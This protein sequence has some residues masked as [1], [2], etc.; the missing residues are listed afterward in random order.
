MTSAPAG[1]ERTASQAER[2]R[3]L[4]ELFAG[5]QEMGRLAD[6]YNRTSPKEL[7][8][9]GAAL[10]TVRRRVLDLVD[11]YE[12]WLPV[13]AMSRCP[14]SGTVV[15]HS[16]DPVGLDGPWW[17]AERPIR[18]IEEL[19]PTCFALAGALTLGAAPPSTPR[20]CRP[21]SEVPCV[22]PRLL[23]RPEIK[24]VVS[25]LPIGP[26]RAFP[27][28]YFADPIP[29]D[30]MRINTWSLDHYVA[31]DPHGAGYSSRSYDFAADFGYDLEPWIRG[32]KLLWIEPG[33]ASL[34][35]ESLVGRC[36]YL[37]LEGRRYPM[38]IRFGEVTSLLIEFSRA[39]A[40][41]KTVE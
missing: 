31:E 30:I 24:A 19:P 22:V 10:E 41:P 27:I 12:A 26:H 4:G 32:G 18:R 28:F 29:H 17:D 25:S 14:F 8:A 33:D 15:R 20:L 39:G 16:I 40:G 11:A 34:A 5:R 1:G 35:L 13:L 38:G 9:A 6:A 7:G 23:Q 37:G 21:G 2:R 36:P 3:I